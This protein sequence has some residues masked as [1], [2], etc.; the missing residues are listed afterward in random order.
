MG[1][2]KDKI[3][4]TKEQVEPVKKK[5]KTDSD[6][7]KK[8]TS[9]KTKEENVTKTKRK[10]KKKLENIEA[11]QEEKIELITDEPIVKKK[12][13]KKHKLKLSVKIILLIIILLLISLGMF[14]VNEYLKEKRR[15]EILKDR[16]AKY[17]LILDSYN[18]YVVTNGEHDVYVLENEEFVPKFKVNNN[19]KLMLDD[20]VV[21]YN[22]E[23]FKIKDTLYYIHYSSVRKI[24]E[25]SNSK[26]YLSYVVFN[27]NVVTNDNFY[28]Y[29][30]DGNYVFNLREEHSFPIWIKDDNGYFVEYLDRLLFI[31]KDDVKEVVKNNNSNTKITTKVKTFCYHQ[32]YK[33]NEKCNSSVYTCIP[34]KNFESHLNYLKEN[35]YL[36]LTMEELELFMDKKIQVPKKTVVITLDDGARNYNAAELAEKY[37]TYMTY[38][39]ITGT[40][41][42]TK[43]VHN[44]Y[45]DYQSH[46]DSLHK[47]YRCS[48]G[49]QGGLLLCE[50]E[51]VILKDLALSQE[52]LGGKDKVFAFAYPFYDFNDRAIKLLKKEGF[53]LGFIGLYGTGGYTTWGT[54]KM[55]IKRR[56]VWGNHSLNDFIKFVTT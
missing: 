48:G 40:Y 30:N 32:I 53:R 45:I 43:L 29:D 19:V 22:D 56:T 6:V 36:T 55:K 7:K 18:D 41:D 46:T 8:K 15:E 34:Y 17:N 33:E 3:R 35:N 1:I 25:F 5:K 13:S 9:K 12:K 21:D 10:T 38:F 23:Y 47:N 49:N 44:D 2:D 14:G 20:E 16:E 11:I 54:D 27:E 24:E 28:L 37:E 31:K 42:T 26:R 52:K 50:K 51:S 4:N 39:I